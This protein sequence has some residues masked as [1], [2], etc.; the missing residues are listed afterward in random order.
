M[1]AFLKEGPVR[2]PFIT[3][4]HRPPEKKKKKNPNSVE[5]VWSKIKR[6]RSRLSDSQRNR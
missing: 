6:K 2:S 1:S 4:H 3:A 5:R